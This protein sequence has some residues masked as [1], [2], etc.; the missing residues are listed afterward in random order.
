MKPGYFITDKHSIPNKSTGAIAI[1]NW[2][3]INEVGIYEISKLELERGLIEERYIVALFKL[4]PTPCQ[5]H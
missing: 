2:P 5:S 4:K 1:Y 3:T